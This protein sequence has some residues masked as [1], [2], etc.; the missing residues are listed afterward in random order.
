MKTYIHYGTCAF[1]PEL[2]T[3]IQNQYFVKP[4]GGLWASPEDAK[5]GWK[6][7]NENTHFIEIVENKSFKFTLSENAKVIHLY[8][9]DDLEGLPKLKIPGMPEFINTTFT[10]LDFEA[11][12]EQGYDAIELHLNEEYRSNSDFMKGLRWSLYGWDCDS[13][14]IMNPEVIIEI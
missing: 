1:M 2:Y 5:Y 11:L 7:W 13:I 4:Q 3:P 6:E 10:Y 9:I 14:L 12:M 8:I